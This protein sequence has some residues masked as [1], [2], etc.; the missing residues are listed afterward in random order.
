MKIT[1]F[2][3]IIGLMLVFSSKEMI[4]QSFP[5]E[6]GKDVDLSDDAGYLRMGPLQSIN[7]V[8][9]QN[10][11]QGRNNG[12]AS[13][14]FLNIEGG[15]ITL[16]TPADNVFIQGYTRIGE[17]GP[18]IKTRMITGT[19]DGSNRINYGR[20]L[21]GTKVIDASLLSSYT[22]GISWVIHQSRFLHFFADAVSYNP[23][24]AEG[25]LYRL[26][27]IYFE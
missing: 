19:S 18:R 13:Q 20:Q 17:N 11:I 2:R 1:V 21:D 10:E 8:L 14:L 27:V 5:I 23:P 16:G 9:D 15:N 6:K 25:E 26:F 3:I 7:M 12:N 22:G 24:I 4:S